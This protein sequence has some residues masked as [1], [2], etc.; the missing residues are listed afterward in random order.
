MPTLPEQQGEKRPEPHELRKTAESFGIDAGRYD[1]AR[2]RYP[3][4]LITEV[5]NGG[6]EVL[7]V[8]TGTGIVA[9]QLE[10]KGC[11]V[12][13]IEP[14]DRMADFARTTGID[15]EVATFEEWDPKNRT[16]DILTA[17]QAWHWVDPRRG[18]EKAAR[19][20]RKNGTFAVFWHLFLPPDD[21]AEAFGEAFRKVAPTFPIKVDRTPKS[22]AYKPIIDKTEEALLE[23]GFHN[24]Q[25]RFYTW[26][27]NYT[28]AEYLD[29]LPTQGGL[30]RVPKHQQDEVLTAVG[31]AIDARGGQFTCDYTTV[32]F[33]AAN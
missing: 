5:T 4:E 9:R 24:S 25:R 21:I 7:D 16:F 8:G 6:K 29:L 32:L 13:G 2:P 23:A 17:G 20:L 14:D 12:L 19:V 31:T 18:A 11:H 15:V 3:D 10:D 28:R 1:R 33:T 22:D 27:Q 30:T 26:Q